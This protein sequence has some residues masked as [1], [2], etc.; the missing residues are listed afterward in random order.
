LAPPLLLDE[1]RGER[2]SKQ[3]R[4]GLQMA[5]SYRPDT[6]RETASAHKLQ[7]ATLINDL[8]RFVNVLTADVEHEEMRAGVRNPTDPAYP[9]L[10]RI[11]C[12]RRENI[13]AT[14]ATLEAVV[15]GGALVKAVWGSQAQ[16]WAAVGSAAC[17]LVF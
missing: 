8:S 12:T 3:T 5:T 16:R 7:I 9:V 2:V 13:R 11:L 17:H 4:A 10:A 14:I 1:M 15:H 6:L